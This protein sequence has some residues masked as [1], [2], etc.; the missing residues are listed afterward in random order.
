MQ[1]N[2]L[3]VVDARKPIHITITKSD[4]AK[5]ATKNPSSC[6][7]ALSC[8]RE[9]PGC[10]QARIHLGRTYLKMGS[11]WVRYQTPAPLRG[12]IISFDRGASFEPGEYTLGRISPVNRFGVR[13][14]SSTGD[15]KPHKKKRPTPHVVHG[16]RAR[17]ANR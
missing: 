4:C 11:K 1:I 12:E 17:G 14:G 15:S 7:A 13:Q 5:G 9:V 10:T 6:A 3:K 2:G 16:V 8:M